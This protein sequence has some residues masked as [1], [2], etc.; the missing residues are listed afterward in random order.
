MREYLY[1]KLRESKPRIPQIEMSYKK[2]KEGQKKC[3][4]LLKTIC[5]W[6]Y[7]RVHGFDCERVDGGWLRACAIDIDFVA[8][9][10]A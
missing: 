4:T 2:S 1:F 3:A 6:S 8:S 5:I 7:A 9:D 10:G